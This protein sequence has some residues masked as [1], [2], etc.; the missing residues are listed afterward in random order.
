MAEG[1][2]CQFEHL[3]EVEAVPAS[4]DDY[5]HILELGALDA[6]LGLERGVSR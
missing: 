5:E 4:A 6:V 2:G 3:V 1:I